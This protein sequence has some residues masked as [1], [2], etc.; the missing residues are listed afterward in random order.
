MRFHNKVKDYLKVCSFGLVAGVFSRF[1][2][3]FPSGNLWTVSSLVTFYGLWIICASVLIWRSTSHL[4][5]GFNVLLFFLVTDT[6]YHATTFLLGIIAPSFGF[7]GFH[8]QQF[9]YYAIASIVCGVIAFVLYSWSHS[10]WYSA[11]ALAIPIGLLAAETMTVLQ[12]LQNYQTHLLQLLLN[13]GFCLYLGLQFRKLTKYKELYTVSI[14]LI[15][16]LSYQYLF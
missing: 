1:V 2:N 6:V 10:N 5:A 3:F 16:G 8:V 12:L 9:L 7:N 11:I 15:L 4:S 14:I 13:A